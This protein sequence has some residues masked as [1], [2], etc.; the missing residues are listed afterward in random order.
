MIPLS[1]FWCW[2]ISHLRKKK[3]HFFPWL[4][5]TVWL[6][7]F[8]GAHRQIYS[9]S[10]GLW[11]L[12]SHLQTLG[13]KMSWGVCLSRCYFLYL[14]LYKW[15]YPDHPEALSLLLWAQW[16]QPLLL[17]GPT[18]L[19]PSLLRYL[20]QWNC[21]VCGGWF[22]PHVFSHDHPH[23]QHFHLYSQHANAFS[24]REAQGPLHLWVS[25]DSCHYVLWDTVLDITKATFWGICRADRNCSCF[26]CLCESYAEPLDLQP[27]E[28]RCK[29]SNKGS[30]SREIIC[31]IGY[32]FSQRY[33]I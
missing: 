6:F 22:Q 3:K 13:S 1:L 28:Q 8:L 26:L 12:H 10:N 19:S 15:S 5:Y 18:T 24:R 21:H 9:H 33:V 11:L 32:I 17:C 27:S 25:T 7:H 29:K 4:V 23:L 20:C 2:S 14:W 16:N 31:Q 30:V